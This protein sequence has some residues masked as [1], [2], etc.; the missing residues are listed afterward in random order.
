MRKRKEQRG[1]GDRKG[2]RLGGTGAEGWGRKSWCCWQQCRQPHSCTE[3]PKS[4]SSSKVPNTETLNLRNL[5]KLWHY[6]GLKDFKRAFVREYLVASAYTSCLNFAMKGC[7]PFNSIAKGTGTLLGNPAFMAAWSWKF[8]LGVF[9]TNIIYQDHS[10]EDYI[11]SKLGY[12]QAWILAC[13]WQNLT[14]RHFQVW[15]VRSIFQ[16]N[17]PW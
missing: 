1:P 12:W 8:K 5:N 16:R 2:R 4:C 15:L 14:G 9:H 3:R 6:T 11:H 13:E 7:C 17:W 10:S